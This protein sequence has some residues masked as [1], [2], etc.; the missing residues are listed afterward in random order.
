MNDVE[1]SKWMSRDEKRSLIVL[2]EAS[3][4]RGE[5]MFLVR[6][7]ESGRERLLSYSGL[8]RKYWRIV[9]EEGQ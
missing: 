5:R 4:F 1:G 7:V 2:R 6:G 9:N 3:P 8:M